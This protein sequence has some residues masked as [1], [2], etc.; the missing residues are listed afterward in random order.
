MTFRTTEIT[1]PE[2]ISD[3]PIHQRL[4]FAYI[5]AT[6]YVQGNLLE[7]GCGVGRGI[8]VLMPSCTHY[9]GLDKYENLLEP[10]RAEY[11]AGTFISQNV[12]PLSGIHT[13]TYDWV[14]AFQVI[15]HIDDDDLFV[16]EL[17]RVL[18]PKGKLIITTP[19]RVRSLSRNPW[20]V[21]EY[22]DTELKALML[23][24]F[25]SVETF[26]VKG[27]EKVEAYME[28]NRKSVARITRYDIFNLQ[29]RLPRALLQIPYDILNRINREK[30]K[31]GNT[32][33]VNDIH[34]TDYSLTDDTKNCLDFFY[35]GQKCDC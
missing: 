3:N 30:L 4:L 34:Y 12:P 5:Q 16:K 6:E 31:K 9:T 2:I 35:I 11:P 20:H 33:L 13:G 21:R 26:G 14:V 25:E 15:E 29:Y 18:K 24:H 22:V 10:L 1:S 7:V 23:K 32:G 27:N 19:N 8:A 17:Q 28:Q